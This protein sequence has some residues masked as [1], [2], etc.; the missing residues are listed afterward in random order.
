[1][2]AHRATVAQWFGRRYKT[3]MFGKLIKSA[4]VV[5]YFERPFY[6]DWGSLPQKDHLWLILAQDRSKCK[7]GIPV[8][9]GTFKR[10]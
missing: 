3:L 10:A 4:L 5:N 1:M 7:T 6:V 9:P 2:A 8:S